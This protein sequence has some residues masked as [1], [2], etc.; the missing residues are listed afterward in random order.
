MKKFFTLIAAAMM[1]AGANA[2]AVQ[3]NINEACNTT[4]DAMTVLSDNECFTATAAFATA[5]SG[6]KDDG[7]TPAG[8]YFYEHAGFTFPSWIEIRVTD[9]PSVDNPNGT[10]NKTSVI[11]AAK[12]NATLSAYVRTGNNK[13]VKLFDQSTFTALTSTSAYTA[14]GSSNNRWTWTWTIEAG[15]TYVLTEKGGTGRLSGFTYEISGGDPTAI[16]GITTNNTVNENAPVYNLAGQ[17][18][19]KDAKGILIQNGR[20]VIK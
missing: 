11:I 14:D 6:F 19:N 13:E 7:T 8:E 1:V 17:R 18:V 12:K 2:Q 15:K 3:V 4:I 10:A 16:D 9:E 5:G 20:K